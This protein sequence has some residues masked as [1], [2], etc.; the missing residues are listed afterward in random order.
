MASFSRP[1]IAKAL[2]GPEGR[3]LAPEGL[4]KKKKPATFGGRP[5]QGPT[6]GFFPGPLGDLF[7]GDPGRGKRGPFPR[8]R[9]PPRRGPASRTRGKRG[10][11]CAGASPLA[12]ALFPAFPGR[13]RQVSLGFGGPLSPAAGGPPGVGA[14]DRLGAAEGR[15]GPSG[16]GHRPLGA[17][18][19]PPPLSRRGENEIVLSPKPT[20]H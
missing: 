6:P 8:G 15:P 10:P 14:P 20:P 4:L 18:P 17:S 7:R 3:G 19:P 11:N 1:S 5:S 12:G 2:W 16:R 13:E 9:G